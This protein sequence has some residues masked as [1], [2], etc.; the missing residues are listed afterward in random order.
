MLPRGSSLKQGSVAFGTICDSHMREEG[1]GCRTALEVFR[2]STGLCLLFLF[3]RFRIVFI[4]V[5]LLL[6]GLIRRRRKGI[7]ASTCLVNSYIIKLGLHP[8]QRPALPTTI[9]HARFGDAV[10][11]LP[12]TRQIRIFFLFFPQALRQVYMKKR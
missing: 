7:A 6:S 8:C 4:F 9:I 2:S 12:R 11:T 5:N 10:E 3:P 1:Q